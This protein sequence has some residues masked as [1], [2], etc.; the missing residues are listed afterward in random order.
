MLGTFGKFGFLA[1][2]QLGRLLDPAVAFDPALEL[3]PGI[4]PGHMLWR[5]SCDLIEVVEPELVQRLL[6]LRPREDGNAGASVDTDADLANWK[7]AMTRVLESPEVARDFGVRA[8]R[9]ASERY[10]WERVADEYSR[11]FESMLSR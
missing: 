6:E 5:P 10:S 2:S 7:A 1:S 11:L 3:Q 4:N 9:S 8:R